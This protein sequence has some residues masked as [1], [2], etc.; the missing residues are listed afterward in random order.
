LTAL[1]GGVRPLPANA[2]SSPRTVADPATTNA[3]GLGKRCKAGFCVAIGFRLRAARGGTADTIS[4][5]SLDFSA[6][7]I[8]ATSARGASESIGARKT[9]A[10]SL[11]HTGHSDFRAAV[12]IGRLTSKSPSRTHRY[13]YMAMRRIV[14][15]PSHACSPNSVIGSLA[16]GT[17]ES[18]ESS[19]WP[20]T[21]E[22]AR[23]I[24]DR[25][26]PYYAAVPKHGVDQTAADSFMTTVF[27]DH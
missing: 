18:F 25:V 23:R 4:G 1:D 14:R 17:A 9:R 8:A 13:A 20:R 2:C 11:L 26:E 24:G 27:A 12:P 22:I 7:S 16:P 6:R 10:A 3:Y 5:S 15:W 19:V 21:V